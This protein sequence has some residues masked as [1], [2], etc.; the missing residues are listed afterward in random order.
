[1]LCTIHSSEKNFE[2]NDYDLPL[3]LNLTFEPKPPDTAIRTGT[4]EIMQRAGAK[5]G[6]V[7][8]DNAIYAEIKVPG[9]N[10]QGDL[11]QFMD[12]K[13]SPYPI[14]KIWT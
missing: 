2:Q 9:F 12:S 6:N 5:I 10:F 1:V 11:M 4:I 8:Y 13:T 3:S 14:E 7:A